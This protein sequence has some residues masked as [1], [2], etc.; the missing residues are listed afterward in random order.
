M[1]VGETTGD[2]TTAKGTKNCCHLRLTIEKLYLRKTKVQLHNK[3]IASR[4]NQIQPSELSL[5]SPPI[6]HRVNTD[7]PEEETYV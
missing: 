1:G 3:D 4:Q 7:Q 5:Y 6:Y 2:I